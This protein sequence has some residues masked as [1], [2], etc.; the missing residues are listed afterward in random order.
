[1]IVELFADMP[2]VLHHIFNTLAATGFQ[3]GKAF[4]A[5]HKGGEKVAHCPLLSLILC[6]NRAFQLDFVWIEI[7]A[8]PTMTA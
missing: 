7:D 5:P 2:P 3:Q 6:Q 4:G 1:M 8:G